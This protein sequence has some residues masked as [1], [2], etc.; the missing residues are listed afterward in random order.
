MFQNN[1]VE[2]V[3]GSEQAYG[4]NK[5]GHVLLITEAGLMDSFYSF[6]FRK[7]S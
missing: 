2:R 3:E 6:Y 5:I 4:L 1:P 7:N